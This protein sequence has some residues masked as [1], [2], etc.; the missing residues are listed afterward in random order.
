MLFCYHR[1]LFQDCT[2]ENVY[3]SLTQSEMCVCVCVS[4]EFF[5]IFKHGFFSSPKV[6][7]CCLQHLSC[8]RESSIWF[9]QTLAWKWSYFDRNSLITIHFCWLSTNSWT[10]VLFLFLF[11]FHQ[12]KTG[13]TSKIKKISLASEANDKHRPILPKEPFCRRL[14]L[15]WLS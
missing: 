10:K 2:G 13:T 6:Q 14:P 12:R 1:R 11:F 4:E 9:Y 3:S 7:G 8:W 5:N 15:W